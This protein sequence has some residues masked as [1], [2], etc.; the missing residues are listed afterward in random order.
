MAQYVILH[1]AEQRNSSTREAHGSALFW[2]IHWTSRQEA[3][4]LE[5]IE[6][7]VRVGKVVASATTIVTYQP[8]PSM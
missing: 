7:S 4:Q 5:I 3:S 8:L 2:S 6:V 1:S